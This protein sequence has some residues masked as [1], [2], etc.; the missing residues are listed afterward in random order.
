[1][2]ARGDVDVH[3]VRFSQVQ[4]RQMNRGSLRIAEAEKLYHVGRTDIFSNFNYCGDNPGSVQVSSARERLNCLFEKSIFK[5]EVN[6]S[7]CSAG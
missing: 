3:I 6:H 1:M 2:E 4:V 7:A 5:L